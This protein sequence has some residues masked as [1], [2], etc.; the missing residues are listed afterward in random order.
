MF[1]NDTHITLNN[2][3]KSAKILI[4]VRD[5]KRRYILRKELQ[6]AHYDVI[7]AENEVEG[8]YLPEV[9][10]PDL[11]LLD[12]TSSKRDAFQVLEQLKN[13]LMICPI[14]VIF[15]T[16][17][18]IAMLQNG[19]EP[20]GVYYMQDPYKLE[21]L[22]ACIRKALVSQEEYK[23]FHKAIQ[24]AKGNLT[25]MLIQ[26]LHFPTSIISGFAELLNRQ[27]ARSRSSVRVDYL[28][29]VIQQ[30]DHLKD[31]IEDFSYLLHT[32]QTMEEVNLIR[33]VRAAI[34]RFQKQ[35]EEKKQ[36][37]NLK[38]HNGSRLIVQGKGHHL[39]M[40]LRHLILHAH[41]FTRVGGT[42]KVEITSMDDRVRIGVTDT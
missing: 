20:I 36:K 7:A 27:G 41:K 15:L 38:V 3:S 32:E 25:A 29:H 24:Q 19:V 6:I 39:F 4:I 11:I 40:A 34:E 12:M 8:L 33:L 42:I 23:K 9:I 18:D 1:R 31:L 10:K 5:Q 35:I 17:K 2:E 14:P 22:Q 21:E 30:A 16:D 37:I 13:E 28:Q 26:E